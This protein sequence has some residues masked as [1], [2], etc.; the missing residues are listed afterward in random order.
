MDVLRVL[1]F[2]F[3]TTNSHNDRIDWPS[4]YDARASLVRPSIPLTT[5]VIVVGSFLWLHHV[6]IEPA[7]RLFFYTVQ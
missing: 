4:L 2:H 6:E 7:F 5:C 1:G 3:R